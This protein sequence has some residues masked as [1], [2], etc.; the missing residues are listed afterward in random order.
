MD[1]PKRRLGKTEVEVTILGLGGE[2]VLR[3]Y[4]RETEAYELIN[5]AIDRGITY[6]ESARAYS[7]SEAYYGKALRERR[8]EIF[9]AS[10]SHARDKEGALVQLRETL[11][12]MKTDYLDLWQVHDVRSDEEIGEIFGPQGAL[13]AFAEAKQNGLVRF[14]GVTGHHDPS[15]MKKCIEQVDFD[16]VLLP[17]NP[18]EP[19]YKSFIDDIL[20][21]A[22]KRDMGIIGMKV[23][24]RGLAAG[25]PWYKTMEPFY[26]FALSQPITTAVIGCDDIGQLEENVE[27]ARSF[28]PLTDKEAQGLIDALSPHACQLMYYKP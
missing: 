28:N 11:K 3:T 10:K 13:E 24:L 15:I 7:G 1:I 8:K 27:F 26:R 22:G 4:G 17:V 21:L 6:C 9:L 14:I 18:A 5:R 20:P 25:L 2:G 12:N 19:K 16:T 23:Y